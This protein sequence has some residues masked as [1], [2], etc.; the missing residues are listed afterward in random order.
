MGRKRTRGNGRGRWLR[1]PAGL[2]V[3]GGLCAAFGRGTQFLQVLGALCGTVLALRLLRWYLRWR[4]LRSI[5]IAEVDQMG[6]GE[7]EEYLSRLLQDQGYTVERLGGAGDLGVD[8]IAAR[9]DRVYAVQAKRSGRPVSRRAVSDAVAGAQHYGCN[10]TMVVTNSV[11]TPGAL[12]LAESTRCELVD[13]EI[14]TGWIYRFQRSKRRS[15][16]GDDPEKPRR[17]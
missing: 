3:T 15:G 2:A 10:C 7:F 12:S 17:H 16:R 9:R 8:L 14:L 11:F 5:R 4:W 6:G 13:R 1:W